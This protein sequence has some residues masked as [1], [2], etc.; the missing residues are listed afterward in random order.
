MT[1]G[2]RHAATV[3]AIV[4]GINYYSKQPG[5]NLEGCVRDAEHTCLYLQGAVNTPLDVVVL[6]A[7][8]PPVSGAPPPEDP[9]L[10]PT[11][12]NIK[13]HLARVTEGGSSGDRVYI[14]YSG[15]GTKTPRD[16][17]LVLLH[18]D[19]VDS[20][21][22]RSRTLAEALGKMVDKGLIVTLVLD[23]CFSGGTL[24][25]HRMFDIGIRS[26]EY[27]SSFEP[28]ADEE[29]DAIM[30]E[31]S[32][33]FRDA[34]IQNDWLINPKGY[35]ILTACGPDERAFEIL[36]N[37]H[38]QGALTHFL[39]R[40]LHTIRLRGT[41]LTHASLY[42]HV[43]T[44]FHALW[45]RQTPMRYGNSNRT[46][47]GELLHSPSSNYVPIHKDGEGRLRLRAGHL[48]GVHEG[49]EF[50][51]CPFGTAEQSRGY[52]VSE[53]ANVRVT[54]VEATESV[55]T[56]TE[57]ESTYDIATGWKATQ[58]SSQ[59]P[60]AI[61]VRLA[62]NDARLDPPHEGLLY[63]DIV[64]DEGTEMQKSPTSCPYIVD[65]DKESNYQILDASLNKVFPSLTLPAGSATQ[66]QILLDVLQH[67]GKFKYFEAIENRTPCPALEASFSLTS[68]QS[69]NNSNK[70]TIK[71]G[72]K[73][74]VRI[75]NDAEAALYI[76]VF[77]FRPSWEVTCLN[78][79]SS[80]A[81]FLTIP[82]ARGSRASEKSLSIQ[83]EIP[84]L[85][86]TGG[87]DGCEEVVKFFIARKQTQIR[88]A[89]PA[90]VDTANG[91][92]DVRRGSDNLSQFLLGLTSTFRGQK[93]EAWST[94]SFV[95]H[96]VTS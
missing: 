49:D 95:I 25:G 70:I 67:M 17:A 86:R 74:T 5:E 4:I 48:H 28:N 20:R 77:N 93:E 75:R 92:Y 12:T 69:C 83:M 23:S 24:R 27:D 21:Y 72:E 42:E 56:A 10:W 57:T 63:V 19:G 73:W 52:V 18:D 58:I 39:L 13:K 31:V 44:K 76:G 7:S 41:S 8:T 34:Y 94:R 2:H 46:I 50:F 36:A 9:D 29:V 3:W 22:L 60:A 78:S 65:I 64:A 14:H 55:L 43:S 91:Q 16:I 71:E 87:V 40:A 61:T 30:P 26:I 45:P 53:R 1:A 47:F 62:A 6:T 51:A 33:T 66:H 88:M 96:T 32:S 59:S 35:T 89:L 15:H 90:M 54:S 80:G 85:L 37:G 81:E 38:R 11:Y 84:S 82:A 79:S 68:A